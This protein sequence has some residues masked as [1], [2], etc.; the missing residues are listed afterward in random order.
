MISQVKS[1]IGDWLQMRAIRKHGSRVGWRIAGQYTAYWTRARKLCPRL[2]PGDPVLR[3][4][5]EDFARDRVASFHTPQAEA[6]ARQIAQRLDAREASG[7][8][9]WDKPTATNSNV[10]YAGNL[11]KDFP[12]LKTYLSE[13]LGPFLE[14][15]FGCAYKIFYATMYKSFYVSDGPKNSALWHSDSGP[16]SCVNSMLY[17]DDTVPADGAIQVLRWGDAVEIFNDERPAMRRKREILG[18]Q[19]VEALGRR[20]MLCAWY[21]ERIAADYA[22]RIAQPTGRAGLTAA[23]ANNTIH[24]GGFPEPGHRRRVVIFHCYPSH[25]PTNWSRY[26]ERGIAKVESYPKDP[27]AEF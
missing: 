6:L 3:R 5:V 14:G 17:I 26:D 2:M 19:A 20:N 10:N 27:A 18:A 22:D 4:A 12:E 13:S 24:R 25:K 16:G 8:D 15:Y 11:W 23:F 21:A 1:Q 9:L 7:D